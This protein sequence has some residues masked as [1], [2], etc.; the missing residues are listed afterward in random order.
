MKWVFIYTF[1]L[2]LLLALSTDTYMSIIKDKT[3]VII[4]TLYI[5]DT[6]TITDTLEITLKE[7]C[8]TELLEG[9]E[10]MASQEYE[11]EGN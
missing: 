4:D 5:H 11:Q 6:T 9:F 3:D 8:E 7:L 10:Y 1:P 2:L